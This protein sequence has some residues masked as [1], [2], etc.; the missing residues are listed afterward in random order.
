MSCVVDLSFCVNGNRAIGD[1]REN[2]VSSKTLQATVLFPFDSGL[3][4]NLRSFKCGTPKSFS[5]QFD[6]F[7]RINVASG[8]RS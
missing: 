7:L 3:I 4:V 5:L 6:S 8:C 1:G 2:S